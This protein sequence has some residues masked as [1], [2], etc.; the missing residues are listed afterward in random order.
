VFPR[1]R[2][3]PAR[4]PVSRRVPSSDAGRAWTQLGGGQLRAVPVARFPDADGG[5]CRRRRACRRARRT[6]QE[7]RVWPVSAPGSRSIGR[8][9]RRAR[10][11]RGQD[12]LCRREERD[13]ETRRGGPA[14][15]PLRPAR[16][17]TF[18]SASRRRSRR[19]GAGR[20]SGEYPIAFTWLRPTNS[21]R[22]VRACRRPRRRTRAGPAA[23]CRRS[24]R[25]ASVPSGDRAT[26]RS[27][28]AGNSTCSAGPCRPGFHPTKRPVVADGDDEAVR[29]SAGSRRARRPGRASVP[30]G[31]LASPTSCRA[32][33]CFAPLS[34]A[35][36]PG[37]RT[38]FPAA[39]DGGRV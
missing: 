21:P 27:G 7:T 36:R 23:D 20:P 14:S 33:V 2:T 8:P 15:A 39:P 17:F 30:G 38:S 4:A 35:T 32:T 25:R 10:R 29:P 11:R 6:K 24:R 28:L 34:T 37:Q 31:E 13:L 1:R 16:V 5:V 19:R 18:H 22:P 9:L 12:P 26:Q 3:P